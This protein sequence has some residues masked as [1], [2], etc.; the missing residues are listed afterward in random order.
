MWGTSL[1]E[2]GPRDL[3]RVGERRG[4]GCACGYPSYW[5]GIS[6]LRERVAS[7]SH[8]D[9]ARTLRQLD[10]P[11][12]RLWDRQRSRARRVRPSPAHPL[13]GAAAIPSRCPLTKSS[14]LVD[15]G[16]GTALPP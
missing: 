8:R 7:T 14:L 9:G 3:A 13:P 16:L 11:V 5:V 4:G 12:H 6:F 10:G 2:A 15:F 1:V